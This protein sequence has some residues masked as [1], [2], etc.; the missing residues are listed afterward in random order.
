MRT[1][2]SLLFL[3]MFYVGRIDATALTGTVRDDKGNALPNASIFVKGTPTGVITNASG[4]YTLNLAPGH[5][6]L[7][8]Q[9]VGFKSERKEVIVDNTPQVIDFNLALQETTMQEVVIKRGE[10]PAL[11]IMK[12]TIEKRAYY[13]GQVDSFQVD[14]YIKALLRSRNVPNKVMGQ[15]VDKQ[16]MSKSGFDSIG[17]GILFLS[18][19]QTKVFYKKPGKYKYQV[20]SSRQ[21]GGGLGI[22]L[23]FFINFY[24]SNVEVFKGINNRGF[25]SPISDNAF[26]YYKFH[27]EGSF[28]ENGQ[29]IDRIKVTPKRK[30]EPLFEGYMQIV[31]EEWRIFSVDLQLTKDYSLDLMDTA[32][33]TQIYAPVTDNIWT[34]NNQVVYVAAN[35]FGFQWTG[36]FLNVYNNYDLNPGFTKKTFNHTILSFDTAF[37]KKD[38]AYWSKV[39]PYPLDVEEQR[40]FIFKDSLYK[41]IRDS[42]F[43]K[44]SLDSFNKMQQPITIGRL[45]LAGIERHHYSPGGFFQYYLN[46]LLLAAQYNTVEGFVADVGQ[47]FHFTPRRSKTELYFNLDT[48]YGFTNNHFNAFGVFGIKPKNNFFNH[49]LQFS[50]GKRISQFNHDNP[51]D[52][53]TNTLYTLLYKR[54]YLKVYENWFGQAEYNWSLKNGFKWNILAS[55]EDRIPVENRTDF[56]IGKK[57][58]TILPNHPYELTETSFNRHHAFTTSVT[59]SYQPGQKYIELPDAKIGI[60]S[61]YPTFEVQYSKGLPHIFNSDVDFDKWQVSV[62]DKMN[63]KI[64]GEFRYLFAIGGFLNAARVEIPDFQHFNGNQTYRA[65]KYLNSFQLAPYYRYSNTEKFFTVLHAEHHFNGLLTN[66]IPL[67]NKLKWNLVGGTNTFY[68]N[69]ANY[70]VEAFAGLENIFKIFR[71]DFIWSYQAAPGNQFGIRLGKGG[72]IGNIFKGSRK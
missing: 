19:S 26:H 16:E 72:A 44:A 33:I 15:K 7:V 45:F 58:R 32:K 25:V 68:V 10:D 20:I 71:V 57:E 39:R 13:N 18:E 70:Y 35:T 50:G 9:Y 43:T 38:S 23:P 52:P 5:Y 61:K 21:A 6:T 66:K 56:S 22:G 67:L 12:K 4:R 65:S 30:Q 46:P 42:F 59:V 47:S 34:I 49:Y 54:N 51:I 60:G 31:D 36:S 1:G 29:M 64:A 62:F 63:L 11:E 55:Y 27:Y 2:Y 28:F 40:D 48:R 41:K 69:N 3:L 14:V 24:A 37:N 53:L 8:C 17:R